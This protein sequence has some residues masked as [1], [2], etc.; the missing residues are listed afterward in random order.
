MNESLKLL[1]QVLPQLAIIAAL[2]GFIGWS[3]RGRSQKPAETVAK[4]K[5]RE[6]GSD[7]VKNLETT[8]E[9][10]KA[11]HKALKAEL[12]ELQSSSVSRSELDA[13]KAELEASRMEGETESR[14]ISSL[15]AELKKAQ[16]TI[17]HLNARGTEANKAEKDRNFALENELSKTRQQLAILQERPDDTATLQAEIERLRESVAVSTRYAG[18][19]RKRES[20]AI[21]AL[22]KAQARI[23]QLSDPSR[24]A[25]VS[26]K[27]GPVVDSGRIAAAKAEVLRIL[28]QN[29][30]RTVETSREDLPVETTEEFVPA[31]AELEEADE[32]VT[33]VE[34]SGK[35]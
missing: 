17:R 27:V 14:K 15:E 20:A 9:K 26:N 1:S 8:L 5:P 13:A 2:C 22:E 29:K 10:S 7:R 25:P 11:A 21:E 35:A 12:E 31:T 30:Q 6:K 24:P 18:E 3:L 4:T 23:D 28:E 34:L 19:V 32:A 33:E 16:E